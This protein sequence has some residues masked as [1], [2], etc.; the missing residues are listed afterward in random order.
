[1]I[2]GVTWAWSELSLFGLH[3]RRNLS[4]VRAFLGE[5]VELTLEVRNQKFLPLT[6]LEVIDVFPGLL[7]IDGR[8]VGVEPSSNSG[9]FRSFWSVGPFQRLTRRF[10][11]TC[12]QRGFH[13]F[14]PASVS[15][16]DAFGFFSRRAT[17]P[18]QQRLIVYPRLYPVAEL[19]LPARN[20]FGLQTSH[21][22]L[23][24]DPLRTAGIRNWR[25]EDGWRRVHWKATARQQ[26][27][28]SRVYEPS[29]EPQ[30]L[31]FLNVATMPRHWQ[32]HVPEVLERA[33]S[34]A[35]SLAALATERRLPVGMLANGFL[36]G[37]DQPLRLLP[38][39]SPNQLT[40]ILE[41][42]ASVSPFAVAPIEE[43]LLREA[44][45][46]PWGVTIVVV[47]ASTHEELL[48]ALGDL[49]RAGRQVVLFSLAE[50]PPAHVPAGLRVYHLPQL[51]NE[52]IAPACYSET[53]ASL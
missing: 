18:A 38:G 11:I 43:L 15:T 19:G 53:V 23:F 46:L 4:E 3:Y 26:E 37:G 49:G 42:L 39:R 28:L 20:P 17:L 51:A 45:R 13:T 29:E 40:R 41:M 34:V 30:V 21:Q 27:L 2:A 9:Q 1:V 7:P 35:A 44:P 32:G 47:T 6:W 31:V 24:E 33:V 36:P 48:S 12:N 22:R 52:V 25:P 5:T 50:R 16:G 10:A 8:P 14:G